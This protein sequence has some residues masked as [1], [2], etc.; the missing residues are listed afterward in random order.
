MRHRKAGTKMG[1]NPSHRRA[2]LRNL[3]ATLRFVMNVRGVCASHG[4]DGLAEFQGRPGRRINFV[5]VMR[6]VNFDRESR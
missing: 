4:G 1:R 3:A 2:T 6:L 5:H